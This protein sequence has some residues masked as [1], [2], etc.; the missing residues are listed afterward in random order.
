MQKMS[1]LPEWAERLQPLTMDQ[2][3]QVLGIC[4]RTLVDFI[5]EHPRYERRGR[6]KIFYPEHIEALRA[7]F[8]RLYPSKP[9]GRW[10]PVSDPVSEKAFERVLARVTRKPEKPNPPRRRLRRP[11]SDLP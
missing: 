6:R 9:T 8:D 3:A 7:D 11:P 5:R 2:A 4:R 10:A 1:E